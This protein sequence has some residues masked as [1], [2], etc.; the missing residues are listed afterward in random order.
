MCTAFSV[1]SLTVSYQLCVGKM[2]E[3]EDG[4]SE[5]SAHCAC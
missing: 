5:R 1:A 2:Y 3:D 4:R